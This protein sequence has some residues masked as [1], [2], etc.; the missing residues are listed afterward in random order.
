MEIKTVQLLKRPIITEKSIKQAAANQYTF[1][2]MKGATKNDVARAVEEYFRVEVYRVNIF[3]RRGKVKGRTRRGQ[4][5]FSSP[6]RRAV[7]TISPKDKIKLF[8]V[9]ELEEETAA[10]EGRGKPSQNTQ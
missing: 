2:V 4:A 3:N 10:K 8:E 5:G 1:E 6:G 7:V 9:A